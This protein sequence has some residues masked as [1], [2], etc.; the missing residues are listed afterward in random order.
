MSSYL[1]HSALFEHYQAVSVCKRRKA[2]SYGNCRSAL[3]QPVKCVLYLLFGLGVKRCGSL[4]KYK[5]FGV[6]QYCPCDSNTL[7][8]AARKVIA[9]LSYY[10]VVAIG[11][12][13]YEV[14]TVCRFCG[15]HYLLKG[16]IGL[17]VPYV[18]KHR[19]A[20]QICLLK[21]NSYLRAQTILR[22]IPYIHTVYQH[23]SRCRIVQAHHK[24]NKR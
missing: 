18:F 7:S 20:K 11:H 22:Y 13:G 1:S 21:H 3:Y 24:V 19:S 10:R 4:V 15:G 16:C 12:T 9:T 5:Y 17:C 23:F 6:V 2:V 8:F 14:V